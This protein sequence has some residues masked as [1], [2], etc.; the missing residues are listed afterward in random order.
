MKSG[1]ALEQARRDFNTFYA[2][3]V[4]P[5]VGLTRDESDRLG[6]AEE[7]RGIPDSAIRSAFRS[8][9]IAMLEANIAH[10]LADATPRPTRSP[11]DDTPW[12]VGTTLMAAAVAYHFLGVTLA[13]AVAGLWYWSAAN[14]A[15]RSRSNERREV[16]QHN[17]MVSGWQETLAGWRA[18][19][20]L[21]RAGDA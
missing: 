6:L 12:I 8:K 18:E 7:A 11:A 4:Q 14:V 5:M 1:L 13:I 21:L 3:S 2:T 10:H 16:D 20:L 9:A 19:L 15:I 17:A